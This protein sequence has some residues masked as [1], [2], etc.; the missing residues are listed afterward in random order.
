M[1]FQRSQHCFESCGLLWGRAS[2]RRY[3][4]YL[5]GSLAPSSYEESVWQQEAGSTVFTPFA[6]TKTREQP[7]DH[8]PMDD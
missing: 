3:Q 7:A 1:H 6:G 2:G 8:S 5:G 4:Q